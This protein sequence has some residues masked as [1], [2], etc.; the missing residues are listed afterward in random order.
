MICSNTFIAIENNYVK[1][2]LND[3]YIFRLEN[4]RHPVV[5]KLLPFG[6]EFISNNLD[7]NS[8]DKQIGIITGPNMAGKSTYLRQIA[9]IALLAQSGS[10]VPATK[11]ELG[12]VDK[13]FTRVGASDNLAGGE[14]TFLVEM[15]ETANIL[16]NATNNSLVILDEIGRGTSTFDGLS[17]AWSVSEFLA[18]S[19]ILRSKNVQ[20]AYLKM[21]S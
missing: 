13:L 19:I 3:K 12:I 20:L 10:F 2:I 14:S 4:S 21:I 6:E 1:P 11:C 18:E 8:K 9:I 7:L 16:N 15:N 17:I 5:E